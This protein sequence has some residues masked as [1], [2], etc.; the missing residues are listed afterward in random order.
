MSVL[1]HKPKK[2]T[3]HILTILKNEWKSVRIKTRGINSNRQNVLFLSSK[4]Y[5]ASVNT[6]VIFPS[7]DVS[8]IRICRIHPS[9]INIKKQRGNTVEICMLLGEGV[10]WQQWKLWRGEGGRHNSN[11][12]VSLATNTATAS[13]SVAALIRGEPSCQQH[14]FSQPAV[15]SNQAGSMDYSVFAGKVNQSSSLAASFYF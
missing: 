8:S 15:T 11:H 2:K 9:K 7:A 5:V 3:T 13:F 10:E 14:G 12:S 4:H 1:N 6:N